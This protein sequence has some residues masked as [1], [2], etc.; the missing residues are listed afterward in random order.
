MCLVK[1]LAPSNH[2]N[3]SNL[4]D[5]SSIQFIQHICMRTMPGT[6]VDVRNKDKAPAL[7][8][9]GWTDIMNTSYNIL[10]EKT[11]GRKQ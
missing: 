3:V 4:I 9:G 2:L 5:Y 1:H 10:G 8:G 6:V 7:V 11:C